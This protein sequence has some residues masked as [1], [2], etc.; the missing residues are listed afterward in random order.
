MPTPEPV[1]GFEPVG[2]DGSDRMPAQ[3]TAQDAQTPPPAQPHAGRRKRPGRMHREPVFLLV[4]VTY[5]LLLGSRFLDTLLTDRGNAYLIVVLLQLMIFIVPAFLYIRWQK[6][7]FARDLRLSVFRPDHLL[8]LF[9]ATVL[10]VSGGLLIGMLSG[11]LSS[12]FGGYMLYDTFLSHNDGTPAGAIYLILAYAALPAVCEELIFRGILCAD[13]EKKIG[14]PCAVVLSALFFA[15]LHFNLAQ[16]PVYFYAGVVLCMVMYVTRSLLGALAVH[17][18][19]NLYCVFW[20]SGFAGFY[21]TADSLG[22]LVMILIG[23]FLLAAILFCAEAGRIY[24]GWA[25]ANKPSDYCGAQVTL[26]EA[27]RV[28]LH[29]AYT[30]CAVISLLLYLVVVI[31]RAILA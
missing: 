2:E 6:V 8:L 27:P 14:V 3:P 29:A 24:R 22:L 17:F 11:G 18:L 12:S 20:Q 26:R 13:L 10:L 28:L 30:P 15:C 31:V 1:Q 16:F 23:A 21:R 25:R 7:S 9:S 5:V 4:L 19:Y